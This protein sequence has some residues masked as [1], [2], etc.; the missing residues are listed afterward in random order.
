MMDIG[1]DGVDEKFLRRE[2][3][4]ARDLRKTRWW[5]Q[6]IAQEICYYCLQKVARTELTMDHIVPLVR[7]GRSTKDNLVTSCK[8]CNTKK[9]TMLPMEWEEYMDSLKTKHFT[10]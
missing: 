7:G 1:F 5:Q 10:G 9:R 8:S 3:A 4:K 6:K 2:R